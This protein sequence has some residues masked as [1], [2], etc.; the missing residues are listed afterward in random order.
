MT[1]LLPRLTPTAPFFEP[2]NT[3]TPAER[4]SQQQA[5][6]RKTFTPQLDTGQAACSYDKAAAVCAADSSQHAA[7]LPHTATAL[8]QTADEQAASVQSSQ[9]STSVRED[10]VSPPGT[11][12]QTP[13]PVYHLEARAFPD[14]Q[15]SLAQHSSSTRAGGSFISRIQ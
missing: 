11:P 15:D 14:G 3:P 1:W 7:G 12:L 13:K 6:P 5:Q 4:V 8:P 10:A 2:G 9:A